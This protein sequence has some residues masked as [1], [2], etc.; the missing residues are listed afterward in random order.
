[1][2]QEISK[3]KM[4]KGNIA[5]TRRLKG[6]TAYYNQVWSYLKGYARRYRNAFYG[7]YTI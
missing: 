4:M 1:M 5:H 3:A 7:I 2:E 6:L